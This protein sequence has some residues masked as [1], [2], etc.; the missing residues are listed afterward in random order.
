MLC[1]RES[2]AQRNKL[3]KHM[4]AAEQI[5]FPLERVGG[6]GGRGGVEQQGGNIPLAH[7]TCHFKWRLL[8][9]FF[10]FGCKKPD[11]HPRRH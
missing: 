1:G 6:V 9:F 7:T 2:A 10:L 4:L 5:R 11:A 8:V 3:R